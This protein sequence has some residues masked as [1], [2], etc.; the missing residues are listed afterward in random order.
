[1]PA[2]NEIERQRDYWNREHAAFDAIYTHEKSALST[3]LDSIFRKDM[4]ER[5]TETLAA[6]EPVEGRRFL[7][8]G[9]G[10]G[11]YAIELAR[12]GAAH[13]RG[14]DIAERMVETCQ[15]RAREAGLENAVFSRGEA[16]DL[17][18]AK[19]FDTSIAIGLFDYLPDAAQ[20]LREMALRT[21]T[22]LIA[23]FPRLLTW[24]APVRKL[25]LSLRGCPVY[26]YSAATVRKAYADAGLQ[27][28]E[29]RRIGK[30]YFVLARPASL[31]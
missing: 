20:T 12:R 26:F 30:L 24:R 14:I 9:C 28:I 22:Q 29:L 13:V 16:G 18:S 23:T 6:C 7:D 4:Y 19:E 27:V 10:T 25:R 17:P 3:M 8:V 2:M 15:A 11:L 5:Y 21:R 31:E 1:M